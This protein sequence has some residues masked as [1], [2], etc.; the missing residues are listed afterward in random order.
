MIVV[1]A[2]AALACV[3][4]SQTT[5]AAT[6]SF[7]G[8]VNSSLRA[9]TVFEAEVSN[10]LLR[11]ARQQRFDGGLIERSVEDLLAIIDVETRS[12]PPTDIRSLALAESLSFFDACYL[13]LAQR[14]GAALA[15]RDGA[16]L[17]AA[18]RRGVSVEDLR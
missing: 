2:S 3:M 18:V 14:M 1:D 17:A 12:A 8:A 7:A 4:P 6:A 13:E 5:S 11:A 15:S 10:A 9:P 16:L